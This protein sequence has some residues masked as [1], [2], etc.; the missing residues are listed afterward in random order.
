MGSLKSSVGFE[1]FVVDQLADLGEVT[2]R[3][4]F[5]GLGLYTGGVFFGIVARDELYLKVDDTTRG[6]YEAA[7]APPFRPYPG[8]ARSGS[9]M[10][11]YRVPL[12][13]LESAP[14]LVSWA[15]KAVAVGRKT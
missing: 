14:E 7:G 11:Y 4:M 13:V 10:K 8:R 2:A 3:K 5:G 1:T 15:R 9:T 6:A 12:E